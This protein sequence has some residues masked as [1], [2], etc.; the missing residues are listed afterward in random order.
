MIEIL[1]LNLKPGTRDEF[2]RVYVERSLPILKKWNINVVAHGPSLHDQYSY[3]VIRSFKNLEDRQKSEDDFY[4]SEDWR[5]GPR[6]TILS[7]IESMSTV[8]V[9]P[10]MLNEWVDLIKRIN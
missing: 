7:L 2:H 1:I 4:G 8:V 10:G 3:Y 5:K 9:S 6:E